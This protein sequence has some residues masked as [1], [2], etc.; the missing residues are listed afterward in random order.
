M[1]RRGRIQDIE[2]ELNTCHAAVLQ[3]EEHAQRFIMSDSGTYREILLDVIEDLATV[4]QILDHRK[5][6]WWKRVLARV[7]GPLL[8]ILG[9]DTNHMLPPPG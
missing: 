7:F 3:L 4:E 6:P 8:R 2:K 1:A 5:R 9:F